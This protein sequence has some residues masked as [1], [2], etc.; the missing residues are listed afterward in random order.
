M[1]VDLIELLKI[2]FLMMIA[3]ELGLIIYDIKAPAKDKIKEELKEEILKEME[4]E[5]A[6]TTRRD[7]HGT[8]KTPLG[9]SYRRNTRGQYVPIQP[10]SKMLDGDD[11]E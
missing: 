8:F 7:V 11:D 4:E 10:N 6:H 1:E 3:I 2:L 5:G 9:D